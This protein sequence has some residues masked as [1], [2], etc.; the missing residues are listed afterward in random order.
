LLAFESATKTAFVVMT[1]I[2]ISFP[3]AVARVRVAFPVT[4]E[5]PAVR[6]LA[7][8]LSTIVTAAASFPT[9]ITPKALLFVA[10]RLMIP[11][12]AAVPSISTP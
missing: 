9:C 11:V 10:V 12:T 5:Y 7:E 3:L 2:P 4:N 1:R 6:L 8:T